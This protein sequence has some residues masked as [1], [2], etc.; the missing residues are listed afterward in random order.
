MWIIE[1]AVEFVVYSSMNIVNMYRE[2]SK[3][4]DFMRVQFE[5]AEN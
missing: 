1:D 4:R 5:R 3:S 2:G